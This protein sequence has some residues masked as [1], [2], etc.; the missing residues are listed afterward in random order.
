[1]IREDYNREKELWTVGVELEIGKAGAS[2]PSR[3]NQR[4]Q[5]ILIRSQK[6]FLRTFRTHL[7]KKYGMF[8]VGMALKTLPHSQ[9]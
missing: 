6:L 3:A 2:Q 8:V 4:A 1:M 5:C 7:R 9:E